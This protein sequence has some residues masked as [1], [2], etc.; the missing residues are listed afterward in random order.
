MA[1][2]KDRV[3]KC[4]KI[5]AAHFCSLLKYIVSVTQ[6]HVKLWDLRLTLALKIPS[7][8]FIAPFNVITSNK[9][10]PRKLQIRSSRLC[11]CI[12]WVFNI[13][14]GIRLA[15]YTSNCLDPRFSWI[16]EGKFTADA[17]A[18]NVGLSLA[19]LV[20]LFQLTLLYYKEDFVFLCN[21]AFKLNKRFSG[22][23][24]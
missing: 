15:C 5:L 9:H 13:I 22:N 14:V 17:V 3:R 6:D 16:A 18:F 4:W 2:L 19:G 1:S 23:L 11:N 7:W 8:L 21:S 24:Q 10:G 20:Y 12:S